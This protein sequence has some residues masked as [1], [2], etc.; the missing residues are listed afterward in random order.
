MIHS[1]SIEGHHFLRSRRRG[2]EPAEV[3]AVIRRVITTLR[4]YE[5]TTAALEAKTSM[6]PVTDLEEVRAA[7][8]R[9]LEEAD[10]VREEAEARIRDTMYTAEREARRHID[11]AEEQAEQIRETAR[12][13]SAKLLARRYAR[14]DD[15][16]TSAL[17]EVKA[18]RARVVRETNEY[19]ASKKTE[20][21]TVLRTAELQAN[22]LLDSARHEAG[23]ILGRARREQALLEQRIAQLKTA[24]TGIEGHFRDLA[25]SPSE[26]EGIGTELADDVEGLERLDES[27]EP[28][29]VRLTQQDLT[30]DLTD[31]HAEGDIL[32]PADVKNERYVVAPGHTIY[33]RRGG[34]H[35][36]LEN[37][38]SDE[39]NDAD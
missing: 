19:R 25:E 10:T 39:A 28:E 38:A 30:V 34:I 33:Q 15:L 3:D 26:S 35:R 9:A 17:S 11:D 13:E 32:D 2:Y 37:E 20:A 8:A 31:R 1:S 14:A 36:R 7:R 6:P 22:E 18:L 16:I 4:K 23:T 27:A 5:E 12:A 21:A 29:V 24:V